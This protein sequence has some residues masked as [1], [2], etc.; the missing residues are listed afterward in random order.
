MSPYK[1]WTGL[2]CVL[3]AIGFLTDCGKSAAGYVERGNSLFNHGKFSEAEL[4]YR[5]ALQKDSGSADASY[6]LAL[7]VLKQNKPQE[8]YQAL[9]QALRLAPDHQGARTELTNLALSS[10]I[11][12]PQH[13]KALYDLLLKYSTEWLQKDPRSLEGLRI[14]AYLAMEE[15]R[16]E[17]AAQLFQRALEANPGNLKMTLGLIDALYRNNRAAE[18]EKAALNFITR[19]PSAGDVYD[20]LYR[21]Y[22]T[23]NRPADAESILIRK[24]KNNPQK[25]EYMLELAGHYARFRKKPEMEAT[26][27]SFLSNPAR[28]PDVHLR[29]GDF[30]SALG[31]WPAAVQQYQAGVSSDPKSAQRYND[32]IAR[33]LLSQGKYDEGL[34]ALNAAIALNADDEEAKSLRAAVLI[35]KGAHSNPGEGLEQFKKLVDKNPDDLFLKFVLSK[36]QMQVGDLAGAKIQLIDIVKR[37]PHFLDVQVA[38]ASIAYTQGNMTQAVQYAVSALEIEPNHPRALMIRGSGLMRLGNFEEAGSIL[39]H[40]ARQAPNSVDARLEL[41]YLDLNRRRYADAGAAF[42]KILNTNPNEWRAIGGLVDVDLAQNRV[43]RVFG[44]LEQELKRTHG[45]P[46]I[47]RMMANAALETGKYGE[48][49]SNLQ[50]LV[51]LSPNS[52]DPMLDLA[53]AY[54][55]KGEVRNAIAVLN[56]AAVLKPKDPRPANLLPFLLEM[57]NR[58]QEAKAQARRGLTLQPEDL[59]A[60]NNLAFVLA[61]TGDSLDEALKLARQAV[62]KAPEQPSFMDTLGFV[63]LKKGQDDEALDIFNRLNR[64]YPDDPTCGYHLGMALFQK[65]DRARAKLELSRA[66]QKRPPHDLE[67]E[68]DDL[69]HRIN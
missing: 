16:P 3:L 14:K 1:K 33:A 15:R 57:D 19:D 68:I 25:G 45:A 52:I 22:Q 34:K 31:N 7:A 37:S 8:A 4:N 44:R 54:R 48:A 41:A 26:L 24:A 35:G 43:D 61:E 66:L 6:H 65:G 51:D 62:V 56:K 63:Y 32:R 58:R 49:I 30:Y 42:Q 59:Q 50:H 18:A 2:V 36:A 12:D 21:L 67:I 55:L 29:A 46:Q 28:E 60:M 10:Y 47:Y 27:Q 11:V 39:T 38:L 9:L 69:L 5:K 53:N 13:P 64:K 20:A 17:E 23:T 40:V